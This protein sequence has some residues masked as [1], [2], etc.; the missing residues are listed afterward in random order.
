MDL[1]R[2]SAWR[3][4]ATVRQ[5]YDAF[6]RHTAYDGV[7]DIH[8]TLA[9]Y[10]FST[11]AVLFERAFVSSFLIGRDEHPRRDRILG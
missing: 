8:D 1:A 10:V 9:D 3:S 4:V 2:T 11:Q 5:R 6:E 7:I